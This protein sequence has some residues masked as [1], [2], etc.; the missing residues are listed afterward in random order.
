[1]ANIGAYACFGGFAAIPPNSDELLPASTDTVGA[2]LREKYHRTI[3][4]STGDR[5][6]TV[7]ATLPNGSGESSLRP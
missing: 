3:E 2:S 4:T 7:S 1:M 5:R 6:M